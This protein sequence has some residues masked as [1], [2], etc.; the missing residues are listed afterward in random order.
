MSMA[1]AFVDGSVGVAL[2]AGLWC[3]ASSRRDAC[4]APAGLAIPDAEHSRGKL[5]SYPRRAGLA[6]LKTPTRTRPDRE[7]KRCV[8]LVAIRTDYGPVRRDIF[9]SELVANNLPPLLTTFL[10][11]KLLCR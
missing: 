8:D 2:W 7:A 11:D 6:P 9:M 5:C 3:F 4:L 10:F 1:A